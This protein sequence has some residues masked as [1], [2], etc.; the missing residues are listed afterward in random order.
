MQCNA[1]NARWNDVKCV[2]CNSLISVTCNE[3]QPWCLVSDRWAWSEFDHIILDFI[4]NLG[5][6]CWCEIDS[7][8][9][10]KSTSTDCPSLPS[11]L[12]GSEIEWVR[13]ESGNKIEWVDW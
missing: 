8:G 13:A 7:I 10:Q 2:Q 6:Q 1:W 11:I 9:C 12:Q 4:E 3:M 5:H